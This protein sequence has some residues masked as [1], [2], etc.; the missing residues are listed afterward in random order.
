MWIRVLPFLLAAAALSFAPLEDAP[1]GETATLV[2]ATGHTLVITYLDTRGDFRRARVSVQ[3]EAG[4][5]TPWSGRLRAIQLEGMRQPTEREMAALRRQGFAP[6]AEFLSSGHT[7]GSNIIAPSPDNLKRAWFLGERGGAVSFRIPT[8]NHGPSAYGD[9]DG[10]GNDGGGSEP[11]PGGDTGGD[12]GD[13]D[14]DGGGDGGDDGD[15]GDAGT[16]TGAASCVGIYNPWTC[17]CEPDIVD[18]WARSPRTQGPT[19]QIGF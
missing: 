12:T 8:R 11:A 9:G 18:P 2:T 4:A 15:D 5:R 14:G 1:G 3:S 17:T 16:C 19:T 10:D 13:G 6:S 7:T